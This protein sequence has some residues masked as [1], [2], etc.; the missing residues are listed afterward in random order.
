MAIFPQGRTTQLV[1]R[2]YRD[3][4][5]MNSHSIIWQSLENAID[6][7]QNSFGSKYF[8]LNHIKKN[9]F[10]LLVIHLGQYIISHGLRTLHEGP[11]TPIYYSD[12]L[13]V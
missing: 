9:L 3:T 5:Q 11:E 7:G 6:S 13:Q 2:I 10:D 12:N 8:Q 4:F 1:G